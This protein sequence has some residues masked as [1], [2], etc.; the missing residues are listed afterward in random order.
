MGNLSGIKSG[1]LDRQ[2]TI[3]RESE[4]ISPT[5]SAVTQWSDVATIR[6]ELIQRSADEFL[7]GFGEVVSGTAAFRIRY[8]ANLTTSDRV[9]FDGSDYDIQQIVE[10]GRKRSLELHVRMIP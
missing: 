2:I 4:T 1:K 9:R 5:G 6:A 3:I 7:A 8:F 10:H